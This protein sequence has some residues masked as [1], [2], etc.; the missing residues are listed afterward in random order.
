MFG[1]ATMLQLSVEDHL[2]SAR[3]P[4]FQGKQVTFLSKDAP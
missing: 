1:C 2:A 3:G 4:A